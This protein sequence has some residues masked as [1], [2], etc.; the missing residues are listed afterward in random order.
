M[1]VTTK[2]RPV[3][4]C[5][6]SA[7]AALSKLDRFRK[8]S[9]CSNCD[10]VDFDT[11]IHRAITDEASSD[12]EGSRKEGHVGCRSSGVEAFLALPHAQLVQL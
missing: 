2:R 9:P 5:L 1:V 11:R 7:Y 8:P 10:V 12:L 3:T 4:D 6:F